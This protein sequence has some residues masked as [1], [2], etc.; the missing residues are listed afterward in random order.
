MTEAR[1][2]LGDAIVFGP[3]VARL[4]GYDVER[5]A[6]RGDGAPR[7]VILKRLHTYGLDIEEIAEFFRLTARLRARLEGAHVPRLLAA[8]GAEDR[9]DATVE[10][11]AGDVSLRDFVR[12]CS[13]IPIGVAV[14]IAR[15][16]AAT[17]LEIEKSGLDVTMAVTPDDVLLGWDGVPRFLVRPWPGPD[18]QSHGAAAGVVEKNIDWLSP[19]VAR[20]ESTT[21]ETAMFACGMLLHEL[22]SGQP[23]FE[24]DS[25]L[26][27]LA[28]LL[29]EP[30]PALHPRVP[31]AVRAIVGRCARK[32]PP[33]YASWASLVDAFD[34]LSIA[35]FGELQ[36]ILVR[37]FPDRLDA[38]QQREVLAAEL[39]NAP[40]DVPE[41]PWPRLAPSRLD[42][43][44]L[45]PRQRVS[46]VP[47]IEVDAWGNDA[48]P[49][50]RFRAG[51]LVDATC[52]TYTEYRRF[53]IATGH[54]APPT[55]ITGAPYRTLEDPPVTHVTIEDARAYAVWAGKRLP[56]AFE[57]EGATAA[58]GPERIAFGRVR[59][60][61]E[62]A[63][64]A[65]AGDVGF[66]CVADE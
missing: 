33:R 29:E 63:P 47:S 38:S 34:A 62:D 36:E 7:V 23:A 8:F 5:A 17:W 66:R 40:P 32:S 20:G 22:C 27:K 55:P 30:L 14:M 16:M 48:R 53:M 18:E 60:H 21:N 45:P 10:E 64:L 25:T 6:W 44:P 12:A 37:T 3:P 65:A 59:E 26:H 11:H 54:P 46:I 50:L 24:A 13:P 35:T 49:M 39:A 31:P 28:A 43:I 2:I 41:I 58:L 42:W 4:H 15:S 57:L 19:E 61:T 56:T 9:I 51:K 52:V 1:T